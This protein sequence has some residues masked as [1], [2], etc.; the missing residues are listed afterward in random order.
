MQGLTSHRRY[1]VL[2]FI[3]LFMI[4]T[5]IIQAAEERTP[6]TDE[7]YREAILRYYQGELTTSL[8]LLTKLVRAKPEDER[9]RLDLIYLLRE[10]GQFKEALSYLRPL[11]A[12][13]PSSTAYY[14]A[15]LTTAFLAG[16]YYRV[17]T[18]NGPE[19]K[20]EA[21]F[22]KGLAAY[23]LKVFTLAKD[24]LEQAVECSPFYPLAYYY[25]G[26]INLA[27]KD[28]STAKT[29]LTKALTQ[30]PNLFAARY[31]LAR[32]YLGLGEYKAAYNRLKQAESVAPGNPQIQKDLSAL[33]AAHPQ[34]QTEEQ[35]EAATTRQIAS[36]PKAVTV[37]EKTPGMEI[38]RVGLAEQVE[39]LWA[40]TGG[41]FRLT[42]GAG[43]KVTGS[44]QK[45]LRFAFTPE[46]RIHVYDEAENLLL[47]SAER[48]ILSY[49]DPA[50]TTLLFQMEYGRG[51]YWAGQA[52]RAYRGEI[53][54][55][56]FSAGLTIVNRLTMEE[57]LY[58]V[59]PSEMPSS[60][61]A[62]ALEAQAI[63]ARTYA[64]A[65]LGSYEKR[66]FD[67]LGSVA[68]QAYNGV[69]SETA[70]VRKAVDATRGQILTYNGKP[71]SAFYSANSG[72]YSAVPPVTWN[73]SPPYL[74]AVPDKLIPAHDGLLPPA[75]LA[76]WVKER[77]E[78]YASNPKYS[79]RSAYRWRVIVP[80]TEIE[81][82][83]NKQ[84]DIGQI[85]G[86]QTLGRAAC[87][88][89]EQV[90]IKGTAGQSVVRGDAIRSTLGGLRSNL[91]TVEP[92]LGP[93]GL[94]EYFIFT[95]AGFGHGVGMDQSGAAGMAADGYSAQA[96]LAHYYPGATLTTLY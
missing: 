24:H 49:Q 26:L 5:Y 80:R 76:A 86:L 72:G 13:N 8:D 7:L 42:S 67:L 71:I 22:W 77:P 43:K 53:H 14:D 85:T 52:N 84:K 16:E 29:N 51:Y 32:A 56:P 47:D 74:Q 50:A 9:M 30:D 35:A 92:K 60:W 91:F 63:A 89:V 34:L 27:E 2:L 55:L 46:G 17:L 59:V 81:H 73:F 20:A 15:Y 78:S 69:R 66:G 18:A 3:F 31:D 87:G 95:G 79:N 88:R 93:D 58:A 11:V 41:A 21:F 19:E 70:N 40:K 57:Y 6:A 90:L 94:P 39:T 44:A 61:P 45:I 33:L 96:I 64:Y 65:H 54:L 23:E 1:G 68:S 25:L 36:V 75:K 82:R 48:V 10:A 28:F 37:I 12:A 83:V 62:A 38:I 4:I